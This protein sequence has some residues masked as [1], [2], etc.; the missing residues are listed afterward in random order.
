VT[1]NATSLLSI[2]IT[3][4]STAD[5]R[6][7]PSLCHSFHTDETNVLKSQSKEGQKSTKICGL[8]QVTNY[9]AT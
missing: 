8:D 1:V 3:A 6:T 5:A 4:F 9:H 7:R 2:S